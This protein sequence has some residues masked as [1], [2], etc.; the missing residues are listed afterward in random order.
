MKHFKLKLN[1]C[2]LSVIFS[3]CLAIYSIIYQ[4]PTSLYIALF[5]IALTIILY[6]HLFATVRLMTRGS[7]SYRTTSVTELV[8]VSCGTN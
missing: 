8:E 3:P 1:F 6:I 5:I 2:M 7:N 4:H